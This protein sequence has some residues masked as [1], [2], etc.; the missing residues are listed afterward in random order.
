MKKSIA[1]QKKM[2]TDAGQDERGIGKLEKLKTYM[3]INIQTLK[4]KSPS[5]IAEMLM[6]GSN[7]G[8]ID[9]VKNIKKYYDADKEVINLMGKL[10]ET[11]ENNL[12]KLRRFL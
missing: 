7:M 10:L 3:M 2:L 12:Q 8:V 5:H 9:A 6:I 1:K 11:E 4:D